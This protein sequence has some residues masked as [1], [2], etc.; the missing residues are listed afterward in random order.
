MKECVKTVLRSR[1]SNPICHLLAAGSHKTV[2]IITT[3]KMNERT[4]FSELDSSYAGPESRLSSPATYLEATLEG[5]Q[6]SWY[7]IELIDSTVVLATNFTR[8]RLVR[9]TSV[10]VTYI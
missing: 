8:E 6:N 7:L 9:C 4:N 10:I 3:E 2:L 1:R 5:T